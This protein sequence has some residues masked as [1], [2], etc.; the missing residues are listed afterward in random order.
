MVRYCFLSRAEFLSSPYQKGKSEDYPSLISSTQQV[1]KQ[2]AQPPEA[3]GRILY[4]IPFFSSAICTA[5][6]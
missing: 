3:N 5:Y 2:A 4:L 6:K 1:E